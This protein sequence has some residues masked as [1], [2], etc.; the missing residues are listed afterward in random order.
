[1]PP[2]SRMRAPTTRMRR[3][4]GRKDAYG[5]R[6]ARRGTF[7][8]SSPTFQPAPC[9]VLDGL[10]V[11]EELVVGVVA[12]V[13]AA[14][15]GEVGD[16]LDPCQPFDLFEAELDLVAQSEWGAVAVGQ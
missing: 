16:E 13:T 2:T 7:A 15:V 5:G 4:I 8:R 11:A 1:M 9:V 12:A 3:R 6:S 14:D 10:S